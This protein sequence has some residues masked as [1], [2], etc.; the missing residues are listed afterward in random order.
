MREWER[1]SDFP[2]RGSVW[3]LVANR[4]QFMWLYRLDGFSRKQISLRQ[5]PKAI[6]SLSF[7]IIHAIH[8]PL[9]FYRGMCKIV[10]W[11]ETTMQKWVLRIVR[12]AWK[13][14]FFLQNIQWKWRKN[15][16]KFPHWSS[17]QTWVNSWA[18]LWAIVIVQEFRKHSSRFSVRQILPL[19]L[20]SITHLSPTLNHTK[21]G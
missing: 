4:R 1:I 20:H 3:R 16:L 11:D 9:S 5:C 10:C 12:V 14:F 15:W 6:E 2:F 17:A 7:R 13:D 8:S 19:K 21:L 18:N